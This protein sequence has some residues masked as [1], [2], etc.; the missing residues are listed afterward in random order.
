MWRLAFVCAAFCFRASCCWAM[1][2]YDF[3]GQT[4]YMS[5]VP[6]Y[7]TISNLAITGAFHYNPMSAATNSNPGCNCVVY[8]QRG[9]WHQTWVDSSGG[10]LM[11]DGGLVDGAMVL[12]GSDRDVDT[13]AL[14]AQ[15]ITWSQET[16]GVRQHWQTSADEGATWTTVFDGHYR[17]S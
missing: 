16:D 11:L 2:G 13:G 6:P 15:Q 10:L 8:R 7:S 1:V 17:P 9:V 4:T 3:N 14:L 5:A 12:R